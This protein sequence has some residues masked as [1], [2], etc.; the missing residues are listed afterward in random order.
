MRAH[1]RPSPVPCPSI[2]GSARRG[3]RAE[4]GSGWKGGDAVGPHPWGSCH[5]TPPHSLTTLPGVS[6]AGRRRGLLGELGPLP[7]CELLIA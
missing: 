5:V 6:G 3:N 4:G 1:P 2:A 7:L